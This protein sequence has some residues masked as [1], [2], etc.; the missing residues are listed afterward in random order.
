MGCYYAELGISQATLLRVF[1]QDALGMGIYNSGN[2]AELGI[3]ATTRSAN[4][5]ENAK[6]EMM[7]DMSDFEKARVDTARSHQ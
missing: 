7:T 1:E 6:V 3:E 5:L 2:I 4:S